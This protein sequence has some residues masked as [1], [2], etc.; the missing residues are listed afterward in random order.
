MAA[1]PFQ[2]VVDALAQNL[3]THRRN[4]LSEGLISIQVQPK[5]ADWLFLNQFQPKHQLCLFKENITRDTE[6]A[7]PSAAQFL[8]LLRE[9]KIPKRPKAVI[10]KPSS[11]LDDLFGRGQ[12]ATAQVS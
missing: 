7:A 11:P 8:R 2:A 1:R 6:K 9:V 3:R 12:E 10:N 5:K 4:Q